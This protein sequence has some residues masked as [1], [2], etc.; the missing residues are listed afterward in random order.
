[1]SADTQYARAVAIVLTKSQVLPWSYEMSRPPSLPIIR[2]F[3][4]F[5]S[6]QMAC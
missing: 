3:G 2:C 6:I 5:G 1:M 4:F